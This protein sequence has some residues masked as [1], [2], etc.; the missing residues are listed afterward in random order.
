MVRV[1][2]TLL[3]ACVLPLGAQEPPHKSFVLPLKDGR[4]YSLH[5]YC[6]A[7]NA[8]FGTGYPLDKIPDEEREI[9]PV[10]RLAVQALLGNRVRITANQLVIQFEDAQDPETRREQ[11]QKVGKILGLKLDAWPH[12]KGLDVPANFKA[13]KRTFLFIHGLASDI[14]D[15]FGGFIPEC[16]EKGIQ[17]LTFEYPNQG[18]I[19]EAA[20][21]LRS[22][23]RKLERDHPGLKLSIIAHSMGGLVSRYMLE[24]G[25]PPASVTDLAT[26][27][28]PHHG[29]RL[30]NHF[31]L[32][33]FARTLL[34]DSTERRI[35]L[36]EGLGEAAIDLR[37]GS[38]F[39]EKLD[40]AGLN[41]RVRYHVV[42]GD[43]GAVRA[44]ELARWE[45]KF[46]AAIRR[47]SLRVEEEQRLIAAFSNL[48]EL[49]SG[50]GDGAVSTASA[51][52]RGAYRQRTYPLTHVGL[53]LGGSE[54]PVF[55]D[56]LADLP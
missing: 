7:S 2:I 52:L 34:A 25:E 20:E 8:I 21:R 5:D 56:L 32:F 31:E 54:N 23:L 33:H 26:L 55:R 51:S 37:P 41:R 29:S 12:G 44:G 11:R 19:I 53:V 27:G 45:E 48:D 36:S 17:C 47:R 10:E 22:D 39:F 38:N 43:K 35:R 18:P 3:F 49:E 1:A 14:D 30:A 40:A 16:R 28:T 6:K 4:Y 46:A 9:T 42:I 13:G 24:V 15:T 50:K